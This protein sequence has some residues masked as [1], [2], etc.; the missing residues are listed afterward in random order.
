[1]W[2]LIQLP[3]L[4]WKSRQLDYSRRDNDRGIVI[5]GLTVPSLWGFNTVN[6]TVFAFTVFRQG[7]L[8]TNWY[9]VLSGSLDVNISETGEA[10]VLVRHL[11]SGSALLCCTHCCVF[12]KMIILCLFLKCC[13]V[14]WSYRG[15]GEDASH[16]R[17]VMLLCL[18]SGKLL[19][20]QRYSNFHVKARLYSTGIYYSIAS[21]LRLAIS[22]NTDIFDIMFLPF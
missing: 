22:S 1:M 3:H 17:A 5:P 18:D 8:G 21:V 2:G 13:H 10:K 11:S 6:Y 20:L 7:D 15:N 16:V 4:L 9:A 14:R 12:W 19:K